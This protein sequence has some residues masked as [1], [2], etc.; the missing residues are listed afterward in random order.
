MCCGRHS[1]DSATEKVVNEVVNNSFDEDNE[2][3]KKKK[4]SV[5]PLPRMD[6]RPSYGRLEPNL[7]G[8]QY[9]L[10]G[11]DGYQQEGLS[12]CPLLDA[13]ETRCRG[14]D[15]LSGDMHQ[16][17]LPVCGVHQLCYLCVRGSFEM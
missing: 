2:D 17:L 12:E 7:N 11:L 6:K 3:K 13:M 14:I 10:P 1:V 4:N 9:D 8:I 15:L 5:R 16:E